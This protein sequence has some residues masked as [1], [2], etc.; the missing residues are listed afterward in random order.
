MTVSG[1]TLYIY[2]VGTAGGARPAGGVAYP[3]GAF[4]F[5]PPTCNENRRTG[6]AGEPGA[7]HTHTGRAPRLT[8]DEHTVTD[9]ESHD[10]TD[11]LTNKLTTDPTRTD[12]RTEKTRKPGHTRTTRCQSAATQKRRPQRTQP[13]TNPAPSRSQSTSPRTPRVCSKAVVYLIPVYRYGTGTA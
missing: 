7:G 8:R 3:A 2:V 9:R 10:R 4:W 5:S 11:P 12:R 1:R 13:D 6:G